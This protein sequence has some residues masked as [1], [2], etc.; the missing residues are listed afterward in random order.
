MQNI[1]DRFY[2]L[3]ILSFSMHF[4]PAAQRS[5]PKPSKN[6]TRKCGALLMSFGSQE[7]VRA[8]HCLIVRITKFLGA[9]SLA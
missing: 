8:M 9:V 7:L 5:S 6:R 3:A 1:S 2:T 4:E